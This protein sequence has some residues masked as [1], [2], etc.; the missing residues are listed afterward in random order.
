[1]DAKTLNT[2]I[3]ELGA[4][5]ADPKVVAEKLLAD[6]STA[7][8]REVAALI[9]PD[10]ARQVMNAALRRFP[11]P[12]GKA[13]VGHGGRPVRTGATKEIYTDAEGNRYASARL[14]D[15]AEWRAIVQASVPIPDGGRRH[16]GHLTAQEVRWLSE[17]RNRQ[18]AQLASQATR[19]QR[20]ADAMNEYRVERVE[21]LPKN[22]LIALMKES[23]Q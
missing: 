13:T 5:E 21:E 15:L 3:R 19:Y 9:L 1:M 11:A 6:L 16:F 23:P 8:R 4:L 10:Y 20:V 7:E 2:R 12:V 17:Q 14:R 18:A 22:E